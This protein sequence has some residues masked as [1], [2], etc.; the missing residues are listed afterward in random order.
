MLIK[1]ANKG[2]PFFQNE[3]TFALRNAG[4]IY[5]LEFINNS[6]LVGIL[7]NLIMKCFEGA[8]L[9]KIVYR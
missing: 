3:N 6:N 7:K 4:E 8:L 9:N 5:S 2:F 1:E